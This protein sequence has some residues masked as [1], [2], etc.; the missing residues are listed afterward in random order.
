[1]SSFSSSLDGGNRSSGTSTN[2]NK[3]NKSNGHHFPPI[4]IPLTILLCSK[5]IKISSP[6][7][8]QPSQS[9]TTSL[10]ISNL[11]LYSNKLKRSSIAS[12]SSNEITNFLKTNNYQN[13]PGYRLSQKLA[14]I[15]EFVNFGANFGQN[16][17]AEKNERTLMNELDGN[18]EELFY[19][20][21]DYIKDNYNSYLRD[22]LRCKLLFLEIFLNIET[23]KLNNFLNINEILKKIDYFC[24][25][26]FIGDKTITIGTSLFPFLENLINNIDKFIFLKHLKL[27]NFLQQCFQFTSKLFHVENLTEIINE[28]QL[29]CNMFQIELNDYFINFQHK[30]IKFISKWYELIHVN[31]KNLNQ[32]IFKCLDNSNK[33]I[34]NQIN[35]LNTIKLL[36]NDNNINNYFNFLTLLSNEHL[37]SNW[38]VFNNNSERLHKYHKF[39]YYT[40]D[41]K[42]I[43]NNL[44]NGNSVIMNE[45]LEQQQDLQIFKTINYLDNYRMEDVIKATHNDH[46]LE[47]A[48][49]DLLWKEF[50]HSIISEDNLQRNTYP[51]GKFEYENDKDVKYNYLVSCKSLFS[52]LTFDIVSDMIFYKTTNENNNN[53][54]KKQQQKDIN[55]GIKIITKL[56][57]YKFRYIHLLISNTKS[58]HYS[59]NQLNQLLRTFINDTCNVIE[60]TIKQSEDRRFPIP[61]EFNYLMKIWSDYCKHI[62]GVDIRKKLIGVKEFRINIDKSQPVEENVENKIDPKDLI[63]KEIRIENVVKIPV[64]DSNNNNTTKKHKD[65]EMIYWY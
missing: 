19:A 5:T 61:S 16:S 22:E 15:F 10:A 27:K 45:L 53:N 64:E 31:Y 62:E 55:F 37:L 3:S 14:D 12:N 42:E 43:I 30:N 6:F 34:N 60:K 40:L 44:N 26:F 35:E 23:L 56:D 59:T 7:L 13:S 2:S 17:K 28:L 9:A 25:Y 29:I 51:F 41:A 36:N 18:V 46:Y 52:P 39:S 63:D 50:T 21:F 49:P 65:D 11:K 47:N 20:F 54:N 48:F 4:S 58:N 33:Q 32:N 8:Y 57:D 38:N 1:M 24:E